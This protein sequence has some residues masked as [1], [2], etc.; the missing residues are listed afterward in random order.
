[1]RDTIKR[2]SVFTV[3]GISAALL[4]SHNASAA[5]DC[6]RLDLGNRVPTLEELTDCLSPSA[7]RGVREDPQGKTPAEDCDR[8]HM[9]NRAPTVEE[10]TDCLSPSATRGVPVVPEGKTAAT[11]VEPPVASL[12]VRFE[13]GSY[14]LTSDSEAQLDRVGQALGSPSLHG[15]SFLIEGHT[16]SVG[17]SDYNQT[18][19]E[20]RA[21]AAR[22]YLVDVIGI[23]PNRLQ[24]VGW[25]EQHL[26]DP[27]NPKS[28]AN[29]RVQIINLRKTN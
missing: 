5:V 15:D 12:R 19:S 4:F 22:Q 9:G 28:S 18:L 14:A 10:I 17:N 2:S 16:D 26:L 24:T 25:G 3:F 7:T 8:L 13:F 27:I 1:M 20:N 6:D 29:R 11:E 23:E 21:N